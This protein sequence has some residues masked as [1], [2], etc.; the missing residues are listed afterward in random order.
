MDELTAIVHEVASNNAQLTSN[1]T[2]T[3]RQTEN[4]RGFS[5]VADE[6]RSLAGR[7][8]SSTEEVRSTV[9]RLQIMTAAALS[10]MGVCQSLSE[11]SN[12]LPP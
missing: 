4:G 10:A 11:G 6:V 3:G 1:A 7:T 2:Q 9:S 5:V 8:H 12:Q